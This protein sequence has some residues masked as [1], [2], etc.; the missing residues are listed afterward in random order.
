[1]MVVRLLTMCGLVVSTAVF[2][3]HLQWSKTKKCLRLQLLNS[4]L[5]ITLRNSRKA[6]FNPNEVEHI[7]IS[8]Y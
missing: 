4:P 6:V 1:M 8:L 2:N 3:G 7:S 5:K